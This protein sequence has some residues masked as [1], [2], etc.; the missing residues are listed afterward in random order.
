MAFFLNVE[1]TFFRETCLLD[2]LAELEFCF[3]VNKIE[4]LINFFHLKSEEICMI[5]NSNGIKI[6][7]IYMNRVGPRQIFRLYVAKWY[8]P[9][10][11]GRVH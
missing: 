6:I 9:V 4:H 8:V 3:Y 5:I 11:S 2:Q 10:H 7:V 1:V